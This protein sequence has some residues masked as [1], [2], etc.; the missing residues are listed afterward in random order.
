VTC[1]DQYLTHLLMFGGVRNRLYTKLPGIWNLPLSFSKHPLGCQPLKH[2][3][4]VVRIFGA[5][6]A[7]APGHP[8]SGGKPQPSGPAPERFHY[9]TNSTAYLYYFSPN[10]AAASEWPPGWRKCHEVVLRYKYQG[11]CAEA[12]VS[13]RQKGKSK[14]W[15]NYVILTA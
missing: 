9:N 5:H 12:V 15:E 7:L 3:R 2:L 13:K 10:A 8:S 11:S 1:P 4:I 6:R 14:A